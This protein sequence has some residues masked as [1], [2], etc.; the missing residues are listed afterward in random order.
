M[1]STLADTV[2]E[3]FEAL[4]DCDDKGGRERGA[5]NPFAMKVLSLEAGVWGYLEEIGGPPC[6]LGG[7]DAL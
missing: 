2:C 7:A 5:G 3:G 1:G 6:G 4:T